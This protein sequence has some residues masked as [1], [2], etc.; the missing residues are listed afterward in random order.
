MDNLMRAVSRQPLCWLFLAVVAT[1][2]AAGCGPVVFDM[3]EDE[4][5]TIFHAGSLTVP[6]KELVDAFRAKHPEVNILT[7]A[8]GSRECARK[9]SELGREC[10]VFAS[11]DYKVIDTLLIPEFATWNIK[12]AANEMVIAYTPESRR[13]DEISADNWTDILL[14]GNVAF[15]RSN[16]DADPCGYRSV[17]TM[18]LAEAH[19]GKP[20][21][22][23]KMLLKDNRYIR[24]KETDLLALLESH[25]IDYIFIYRSVAVQHGLDLLPLPA[26]INL[27]DAARADLYSTAAVEIAGKDP[28]SA[29]TRVGEPMVY[30]VT[31]PAN[32]PHPD[33]AEQFVAFLLDAERG[34]AILEANGQ[35]SLVPSP[36]PNYAQLPEALKAFAK[37]GAS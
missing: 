16:P 21:L 3:S 13:A 20:G 35:P 1:V 27:K 37:P 34:M 19:Y 10:D 32:A 26:E 23:E 33:L 31:I 15:G 7:E 22:A 28:G 11:A 4:T 6:M 18:R 25:T 8:A 36:T 9:I 17:L 24:P 5:L 12:F 29:I 14:D 30:G 2:L